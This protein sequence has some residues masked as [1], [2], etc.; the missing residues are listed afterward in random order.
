MADEAASRRVGEQRAGPM[1]RKTLLLEGRALQR[2]RLR[3]GLRRSVALHRLTGS[4]RSSSRHRDGLERR[5]ALPGTPPN[6]PDRMGFRAPPAPTHSRSTPATTGENPR[7]LS[8]AGALAMQKVE[9]SSPFIRFTR[10]PAA[11]GLLRSGAVR[12]GSLGLRRTNRPQHRR[13]ARPT[14][15]MPRPP[16]VSGRTVAIARRGPRTDAQLRCRW[17]AAPRAQRSPAPDP[18]GGSA[19]PAACRARAVSRGPGR[20]RR[21]G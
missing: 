10:R 13:G 19:C 4:A 7:M 3:C 16:S 17:R 1:H 20:S 18:P 12:R 5:A 15:R 11:A 9:G 14:R 2:A 21:R 6:H 8:A